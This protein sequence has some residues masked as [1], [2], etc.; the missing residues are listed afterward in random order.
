MIE[1]VSNKNL[2]DVLPLIRQYQEFY[3]VEDICDMRNRVFFSRFGEQSRD[4]CQFAYRQAGKLVAFATV[5]FTYTSTIAAK[6]GVLNDLFTLPDFQNRGIGRELIEH[7]RH[8]AAN[9][10][11]ARLQWM[12]ASDNLHAQSLYDSMSTGKSSWYFYTYTG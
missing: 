3:K 8:Y 12:T 4:G 6:V 1:A 11:A 2:E 7:C 5:Y 10:G 9:R